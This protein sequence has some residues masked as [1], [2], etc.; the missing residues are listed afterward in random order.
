MTTRDRFF[1]LVML[2]TLAWSS[3]AVAPARAQDPSTK[4]ITL[5][6]PYPAG[7]FAD[8]VTR[9]IGSGLARALGQTVVVDN[10]PGASG[11][12]GIDAL[13]RVP[14]DGN[15]LAAV[16]PAILS[17][18]PVFDPKYRNLSEQVTPVTLAVR[19]RTA[20][21]VNPNAIPVRDMREFAAYLKA[22]PGKLSYGSHGAGTLS[23]LWGEQISQSLG[24]DATHVP[25][26]GEAPAVNDLLGGQVQFVLVTGSVKP[27]V[28][29]GKLKLIAVSGVG[30]WP[31]VPDVPT[32]Q[33]LGMGS[34]DPSGWLAFVAPRAL[35]AAALERLHA[36]F[37]RALADPEV[38]K[39]LDAQGYDIVGSSPAELAAVAQG[40][41]ETFAKLYKSGRI[42]LE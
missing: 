18:L 19:A 23:H 15:T 41:T 29:A 28:D 39:L 34:I 17:L 22:N 5:I 1:H 38:R 11:K 16:V 27:L 42:K 40:Q 2:V 9:T 7:G 10:R 20:L 30:R 14:A 31:L 33:E 25:Y 37:A 8:Y 6:V 3:L 36:G 35:P 21:A 26:K 13:M 32:F 12:I 24:G 4:P